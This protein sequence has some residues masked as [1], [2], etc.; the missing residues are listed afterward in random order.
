M[1]SMSQQGL[2]LELKYATACRSGC[3]QEDRGLSLGERSI[4]GLTVYGFSGGTTYD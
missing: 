4:I 2:M 3:V 1:A